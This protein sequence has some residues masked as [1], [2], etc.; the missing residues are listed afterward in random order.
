M[1]SSIDWKAE[2]HRLAY[3]NERYRRALKRIEKWFGEFPPSGKFFPVTTNTELTPMSYGM[4]FGSNGE[5]DYMRG[6]ARDALDGDV[7][8]DTKVAE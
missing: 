6:V 2:A 3:E 8:I 1:D 7:V 5:R 4:A